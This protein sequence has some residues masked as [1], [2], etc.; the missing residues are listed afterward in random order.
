VTATTGP[1]HLEPPISPERM[2]TLMAGLAEITAEE[3]RMLLAMVV[4]GDVVIPTKHVAKMTIERLE[5]VKCDIGRLESHISDCIG[6][7]RA[8]G[9]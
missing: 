8:D 4:R 7:L 2:A 9:N 1:L 5:E 3:G 6:T